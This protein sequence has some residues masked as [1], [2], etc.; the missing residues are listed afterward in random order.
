[1]R[2]VDIV[3]EWDLDREGG[4]VVDIGG[5]GNAFMGSGDEWLYV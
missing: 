4:A 1:M 3:V 5:R 2:L